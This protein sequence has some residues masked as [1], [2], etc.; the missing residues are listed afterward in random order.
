MSKRIPPVD[1]A[2]VEGQAKELFGV[3]KCKFGMVPNALKTMAQSPAVLDGYLSLNSSLAKGK[4]SKS[5]REQIA[6]AVS[7]AN[8]CE[9]CL[10]VH[11]VTAKMAGL[12]PD[13]VTAARQG[14]ST[15]PKAQAVLNLTHNILERRGKVSDS[16]LAEARAAGLTDAELVEVVGNVTVMTLT[17][18]LNNI[19]QTEVDF[20]RVSLSI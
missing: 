17:N 12:S 6:L 1:P 18:F 16:Q 15:D 11:S 5:L 9:Y 4:L 2:T 14:K 8:G 7:Q 3:I 20:P 13:Q 10:A 19:S